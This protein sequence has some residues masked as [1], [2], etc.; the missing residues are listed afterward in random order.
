MSSR[1][2]IIRVPLEF[3]QYIGEVSKE[4]DMEQKMVLK[5][6]A[7]LRPID[8]KRQFGSNVDK[9]FENELP[10]MMRRKRK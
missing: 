6:I 9:L 1:T 3:K 7:Q 2:R 10:N 8:I 4:L 5:R